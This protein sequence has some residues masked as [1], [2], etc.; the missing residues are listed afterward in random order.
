MSYESI[1]DIDKEIIAQQNKLAELVQSRIR[2]QRDTRTSSETG[3]LAI[4]LHEKQCRWNHTDGCSWHYEIHNGVPD[5]SGH[6]HSKYWN[7]AAQI[8]KHGYKCED[9][10]D[11]VNIINSH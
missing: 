11:I 1:S 5:W 7:I 4:F 9:V 10:T 8:L 6:A 2:M 3:Q